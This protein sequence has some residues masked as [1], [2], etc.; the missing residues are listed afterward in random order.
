MRPTGPARPVLSGRLFGTGNADY[1]HAVSESVLIERAQVGSARRQVSRANATRAGRLLRV[2]RRLGREPAVPLTAALGLPSLFGAMVV[3]QPAVAVLTLAVWAGAVALQA[4]IAKANHRWR[5]ASRRDAALAHLVVGLVLV[6]L[7]IALVLPESF[8]LYVPVVAVAAAIGRREGF[9]VGIMAVVLVVGSR[10]NGL[11]GLEPAVLA[12]VLAGV[13]AMTLI[14]VGARYHVSRRERATR[15]LRASIRRERRRSRQL[16]GVEEVGRLLAVKGPTD[17]ALGRIMDV[18]VEQF[19]YPYPSIYLLGDDGIL[20]LGAQRGYATPI[21]RFDGSR[22]VVG[23]VLREGRAQLVVDVAA[24]PD[25]VGAIPGIVSEVS[26]PLIDDGRVLGILNVESVGTPLDQTDL[27]AIAAVANRLTAYLALARER[28]R[29]AELTIRDPLTGLH[30]RRFLDDMIEMLFAARSR[31]ALE[32]RRAMSVALFDLDHFG[33]LNNDHGHAAGDSVL[34]AVAG[35]LAS[36]FRSSDLVARYGGEEF[37]VVLD[38][39]TLQEAAERAEQIRAAL[40]GTPVIHAGSALQ[41][42]LSAGCASIAATQAGSWEELLSAADV[43]L[44]M[45]KRGGRNQVVRAS[46]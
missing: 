42:T 30:N 39:A 37:V 9:L 6:A 35:Q 44:G 22:G 43:A 1:R 8:P 23:R 5:L 13:V 38:G 10:L 4:V 32:D 33:A 2:A 14:A 40:A 41:V 20:E 34:R 12:R 46:V 31:L 7:I 27:R 45:A 25:Y 21:L 36:G 24:D 19:G 26:A 11:T 18:L 28:Q 16:S 15:A 3:D 17:E 29:L